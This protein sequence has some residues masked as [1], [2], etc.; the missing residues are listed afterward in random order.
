MIV[1]VGEGRRACRGG[2]R[3]KVTEENFMPRMK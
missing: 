1:Y 3:K 2:D